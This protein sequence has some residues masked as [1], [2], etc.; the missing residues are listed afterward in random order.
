MQNGCSFKRC[1]TNR[2]WFILPV[3]CWIDK[4]KKGTP[5][6]DLQRRAISELKNSCSVREC[7]TKCLWYILPD[8]VFFCAQLNNVHYFLTYVTFLFSLS[9]GKG[10][11]NTYK[12]D[13]TVNL[14]SAVAGNFTVKTNLSQIWKVITSFCVLQ[15]ARSIML[16][17]SKLL[18]SD[19]ILIDTKNVS[20]SSKIIKT[21]YILE[22]NR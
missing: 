21:E 4:N 11:K 18:K 17:F 2:L 12:I 1:V 19:L 20:S 14:F 7:V 9:Y 22:I 8:W 5:G 16:F 3:F 10:T 15:P 6:K 13:A